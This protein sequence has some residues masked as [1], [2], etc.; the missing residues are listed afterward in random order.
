MRLTHDRLTLC[1]DRVT[2][3]LFHWED[4]N[5]YALCIQY[6]PNKLSAAE[7]F[8]RPARGDPVAA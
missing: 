7:D 8:N 4:T 2:V 6:G 5:Q 3:S 1:I